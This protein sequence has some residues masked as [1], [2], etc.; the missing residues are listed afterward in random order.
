MYFVNQV[1]RLSTGVFRSIIVNLFAMTS[2]NSTTKIKDRNLCPIQFSLPDRWKPYDYI[3]DRNLCP[4]QFSLLDRWKPYDYIKDRN[5]CLVPIL[6]ARQVETLQLK[7]RTEICAW[8]NSHCQ[9]GGDLT[10]TLRTE[11][12]AQSNSHCW[13][14]GN[15]TSK[16]KDRNLCSIQFSLPDM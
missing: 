4:V 7:L 3:K 2:R 12:C 9:I 11:T 10:T 8:S 6:I 15:L 13:T 1:Q 16:I 5:L 14:G